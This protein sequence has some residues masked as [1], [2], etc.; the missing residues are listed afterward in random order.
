MLNIKTNFKYIYNN[1]FSRDQGNPVTILTSRWNCPIFIAGKN[2]RSPKTQKKNK[3]KMEV[4]DILSTFSSSI[5]GL[6]F[7]LLK[8]LVELLRDNYEEQR[9]PLLGNFFF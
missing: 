8:G 9:V 4:L 3:K 7:I 1:F 5:K 2:K 6:D